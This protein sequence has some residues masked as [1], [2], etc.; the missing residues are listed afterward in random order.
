MN[1]I[2]MFMASER[3]FEMEARRQELEA[4]ERAWR[5]ENTIRREELKSMNLLLMQMRSNSSSVGTR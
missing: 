2:L 1:A 5:E 3:K 4:A